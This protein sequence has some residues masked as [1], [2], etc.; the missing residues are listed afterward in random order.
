MESDETC[1]NF[2]FSV[3]LCHIQSPVLLRQRAKEGCVI[4]EWV[5]N[6]PFAKQIQLSVGGEEYVWEYGAGFNFE[7]QSGEHAK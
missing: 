6:I 5:V 7:G 2:P 4:E 3:S 1:F